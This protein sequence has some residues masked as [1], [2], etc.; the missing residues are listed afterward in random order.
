MQNSTEASSL[1]TPPEVVRP[2]IGLIDWL[3]LALAIASIGLLSWETFWDVSERTTRLI[4]LSDYL[5]CAVFALEF[6]WRWRAQGWDRSYVLRNWYEILGM[7]PVSSPA[8]RGF[9]LFR[10]VRIIVLL[11]RFG[12]AADRAFG[13]EFTYRIITRF[14]K[15]FVDAIKG[16]ITIGVL[17]EVA[18]VLQRGHYTRNIARALN[19]NESEVEEMILEK[20]REDPQTGRLRRVPFYDEIVRS[21]VRAAY[22]VVME[23]LN[24]PRTDELV[25]DLL[26]ENLT[27]IRDSVESRENSRL[28]HNRSA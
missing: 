18:T 4:I 17:E 28:R 21:V 16:P 25:S 14:R 8:F 2:R 15:G 11:S 20:L 10:V 1:V 27:Q 13:D 22:R 24:D 9:R 26:R 6:V 3:M 12:K 23:T 5:I 7:I 19:E